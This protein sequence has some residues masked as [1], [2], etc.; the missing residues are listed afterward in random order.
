MIATPVR[1]DRE[2]IEIGITGPLGVTLKVDGVTTLCKYYTQNITQTSFD[3]KIET[4]KYGADRILFY[5]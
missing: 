5:K 3:L 2:H 4:G 1:V